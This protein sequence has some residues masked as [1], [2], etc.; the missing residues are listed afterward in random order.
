MLIK[1]LLLDNFRSYAKKSFEFSPGTT[2]VVG[3][4]TSGKSNLLEAIFLLAFGKSPRA[5]LDREMVKTEV[6]ESENPIIRDS[7]NRMAFVRAT[8]SGSDD[9]DLEVVLTETGKRFRVNGVGRRLSDFSQHFHVVLFS[10]E[11]LNLVTGTPDLR[12]RF[13]DFALGSVDQA[14]ARHLSEYDKVRRRRNRILSE[15]NKNTHFPPVNLEGWGLEFWDAKLLEHGVLLQDKRNE[16]FDEINQQLAV[17]SLQLAYLPSSLTAER[18]LEM[19][20]REIA[21]ETSLIGPHRDDFTF[22]SI[23]NSRQLTEVTVNRELLTVNG[24]DLAA[25]GSR[26][27]QRRAVLAL[28]EAELRFVEKRIENRPVLLLDDIFSELDEENRAR[29]FDLIGR[30]HDQ[31]SAGEVGQTIITTTDLNHV[32]APLQK[33]LP[34]IRL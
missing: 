1:K 3:A 27:E 2:L 7:G 22:L 18:L 24:R 28:K 8:V 4:N 21:A 6:G 33:D 34:V 29:V 11:D 26:G 17:S 30:G 16:F 15:M 20:P 19:R 5:D 23:V 31:R 14:Y 32:P 25:Y 12:R 10:P 13:M 9:R